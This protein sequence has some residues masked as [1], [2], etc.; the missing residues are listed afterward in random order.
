M[1]D[2]HYNM[3]NKIA[4]QSNLKKHLMNVQKVNILNFGI[5]MED[6]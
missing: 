1:G 4:N 6:T 3:V 5:Q 2:I